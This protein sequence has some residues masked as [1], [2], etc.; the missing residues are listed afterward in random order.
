MWFMLTVYIKTIMPDDDLR[1]GI[2]VEEFFP[3]LFSEISLFFPLGRFK[4]VWGPFQFHLFQKGKYFIEEGSPLPRSQTFPIFLVDKLKTFSNCF[5]LYILNMKK[6]IFTNISFLSNEKIIHVDSY[7][8][9]PPH[10]SVFLLKT[11][12]RK[13]SKQAI[14]GFLIFFWSFKS[15]VSIMKTYASRYLFVFKI[16]QDS[17]FVFTAAD[18]R[19]NPAGVSTVFLMQVTCLS[20]GANLLFI[21]VIKLSLEAESY[22]NPFLFCIYCS[23]MLCCTGPF[24]GYFLNCDCCTLTNAGEGKNY[25]C[26]G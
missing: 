14:G 2:V 11:W 13:S 21:I 10:P 7:L 3:P 24:H 17:C 23:E 16:A 20:S 19:G 15:L 5:I 26:E 18:W 4:K 25:Y 1:G 9:A 22:Y 6:I 12:K 8:S